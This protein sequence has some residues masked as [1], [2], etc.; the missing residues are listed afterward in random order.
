METLNHEKKKWMEYKEANYG[1]L[2][3]RKEKV[4]GI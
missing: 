4:D 2:K 1:N 3:S